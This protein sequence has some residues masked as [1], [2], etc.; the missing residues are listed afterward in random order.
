LK[1]LK[2]PLPFDGFKAVKTV[3]GGAH[4]LK[5]K[6]YEVNL[7]LALGKNELGSHP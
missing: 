5:L 7:V 4:S 2:P 6:K 1:N 3:I